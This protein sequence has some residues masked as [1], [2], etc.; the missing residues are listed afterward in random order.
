MTST[1]ALAQGGSMTIDPQMPVIE[2][3]KLALERHAAIIL[4]ADGQ[5]VRLD[6][7]VRV[8]ELQVRVFERGEKQ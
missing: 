7:K 4:E 6:T 1:E 3:A 8:G 5:S 2:A